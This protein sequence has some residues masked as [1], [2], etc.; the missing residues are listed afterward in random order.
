MPP[1]PDRSAVRGDGA[2]GPGLDLRGKIQ[3]DLRQV[4]GNSEKMKTPSEKLVRPRQ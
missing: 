1:I 4:I 3:P 2:S